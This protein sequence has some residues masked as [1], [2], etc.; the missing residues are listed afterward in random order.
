MRT[1]N[2]RFPGCSSIFVENL[3]NS[4]DSGPWLLSQS[5]DIVFPFSFDRSVVFPK[6]FAH[7]ELSFGVALGC[8]GY[9]LCYS[10][11][12]PPWLLMLDAFRF[13]EVGSAL[14][15]S[16]GHNWTNFNVVKR[17]RWSFLFCSYNRNRLVPRTLYS[18]SR[19][20]WF[21]P[22]PGALLRFALALPTR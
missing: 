18:W 11:S 10:T 1:H 20:K 12:G 5:P 8:S 13:M 19:P 14:T 4:D 16:T 7:P 3:G 21:W 6:S 22:G 2:F 15:C 9:F 17:S